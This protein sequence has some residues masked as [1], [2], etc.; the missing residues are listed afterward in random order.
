MA[1]STPPRCRYY[2]LRT[3]RRIQYRLAVC[4]TF[5]VEECVYIDVGNVREWGPECIGGASAACR[6]CGFLGKCTVVSMQ[7]T[8]TSTHTLSQLILPC[9]MSPII[10]MGD[11]GMLEAMYSFVIYQLSNIY[12]SKHNH[13]VPGNV[14][15]FV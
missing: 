15:I 10:R 9:F 7:D 14:T 12:N 4:H 1:N 8:T 5:C 13:L 3:C 11:V 6:G 2:N